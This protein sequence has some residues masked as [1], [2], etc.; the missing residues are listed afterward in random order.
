MLKS[1]RLHT[2]TLNINTQNSS[3]W[4]GFRHLAH[5][6]TGHYYNGLHHSAI[7]D[8]SE[9]LRNGIHN[10]EYFSKWIQLSLVI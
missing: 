7:H 10:C 6:P 3:Q 2:D 5:Q 9:P 8:G 1:S 4:D